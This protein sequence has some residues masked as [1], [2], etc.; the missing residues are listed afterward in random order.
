MKIMESTAGKDF[1]QCQTEY[2]G[3]TRVYSISGEAFAVAVNPGFGG[4]GADYSDQWTN[5]FC[6]NG[7]WDADGQTSIVGATELK[8]LI[9]SA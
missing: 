9:F 1:T 5:Y 7:V 3:N 2:V 6:L 8:Q 4:N